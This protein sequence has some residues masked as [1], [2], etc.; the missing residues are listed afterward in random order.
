MKAAF[1]ATGTGLS[2]VPTRVGGTQ[3]VGHVLLALMNV[4]R[5]YSGIVLHLQQ[6]VGNQ[7]GSVSKDQQAKA[8]AYLKM[9]TSK[10]M[11]L[12]MHLMLDILSEL[13]KA[14]MSFQERNAT[15][16]DIHTQLQSVCRVLKKY[17]VSDGPYLSKVNSTDISEIDGI[18]LVE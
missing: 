2:L 7:I 6:L 16:A 5:G 14:F 15:A 10:D 9:L 13:K 4:T 11:V 8:K 18:Q 17:E 3:W 1:K 12:V